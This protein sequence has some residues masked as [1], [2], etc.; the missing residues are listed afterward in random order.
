MRVLLVLNIFLKK[1]KTKSIFSN[2]I[3]ANSL[4]VKPQRPIPIER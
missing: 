4:A 2:F 1:I 3:K